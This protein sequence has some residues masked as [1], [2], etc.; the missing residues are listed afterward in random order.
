MATIDDIGGAT[1]SLGSVPLGGPN[2]WAAAVRDAITQ[3]QPPPLQQISLTPG[4]GWVLPAGPLYLIGRPKG[5]CYLT[6]T[7]TQA[8]GT[9]LQ[10]LPDGT[11][12]AA[13][14]PPQNAMAVLWS[15]VSGNQESPAS[16]GVVTG[17]GSPPSAD[18]LT[19][20]LSQ[21]GAKT[22]TPLRPH[23]PPR[24]FDPSV[25]HNVRGD[26]PVTATFMSAR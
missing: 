5:A 25:S 26:P 21:S 1:D 19:S 15:F 16:S 10:P 20:P 2:G 13:L 7:I 3:L 23:V 4:N 14:R 12:P 11:I 18:T 6:G 24:A 8:S 17:C 22:M 9:S